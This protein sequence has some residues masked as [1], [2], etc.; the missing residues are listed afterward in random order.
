MWRKANGE[1]VRVNY[2]VCAACPN[3]LRETGRTSEVYASEATVKMRAA[4]LKRQ[5]AWMKVTVP[6][7]RYYQG[8]ESGD[9]PYEPMT[10]EKI[11]PGPKE[12]FAKLYAFVMTIGWIDLG[13]YSRH[14]LP[15]RRRSQPFL[16][17][18]V[19]RHCAGRNN[20]GYAT[21]EHKIA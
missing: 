3:G 17:R 18:R 2:A 4:Q 14:P 19:I 5:A 7:P 9:K 15:R 16:N 20:C 10:L 21:I 12:R 6:V 13:P 8:P 1:L 11:A